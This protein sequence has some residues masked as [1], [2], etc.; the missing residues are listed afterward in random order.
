MKKEV[1]K[2]DHWTYIAFVVLNLAVFGPAVWII[3]MTH[4]RLGSNVWVTLAFGT[5]ILAKLATKR[6]EDRIIEERDITDLVLE[7]DD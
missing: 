2:Y 5:I 6:L 4:N 1:P 3:Y 7:N